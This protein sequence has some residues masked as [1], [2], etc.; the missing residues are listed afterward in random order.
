LAVRVREK[1]IALRISID[2]D[3]GDY[4]LGDGLRIRQILLNLSGNAVKFTER[5]EVQ[6]H[7]TRCAS[8]LH[9]E[10]VDTGIGIPPEARDRLFSSFSQVD[11]STTRRFGGTGLGLAISKKLTEGMGGT[12]GVDS[13]AGEGSRFWFS[14]PLQRSEAPIKSESPGTDL[15]QSAPTTPAQTQSAVVPH[16][17]LVEDHPV[18]QKLALALLARLGYTADL[19]ENG[20]I[21]VQAAAQ[22]PYALILMD[23]QMPDMDGL[24]ATRIIRATDNPN[25][26]TYIIA[27]TANAM[28]SDKDA[29]SAAGMNAFLS[30]P[31]NREA[32][33]ECIKKGLDKDRGL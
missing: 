28:Q 9:F 26:H 32:L 8:E 17:L 27:L 1:G 33:A 23:M 25:Q 7:V 18:N 4:F 30:K 13:V 10:V 11:A 14:L 6:I 22:R 12:I 3:A 31:F 5:G 20:L 19:A 16:I 15:P 2:P 29:C 24:E 21:A